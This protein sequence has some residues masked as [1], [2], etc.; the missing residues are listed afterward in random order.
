MALTLEMPG[1]TSFI[2]NPDRSTS[3]LLNTCPVSLVTFQEK[4]QTFVSVSPF[5]LAH[6]LKSPVSLVSAATAGVSGE[7]SVRLYLKAR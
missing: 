7:K 5:Q 6:T 2:S 4:R 1:T 3:L